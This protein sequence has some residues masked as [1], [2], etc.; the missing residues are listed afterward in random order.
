V[1]IDG[2]TPTDERQEVQARLARGD[3]T[4]LVLDFLPQMNRDL[5]EHAKPRD[6]IDQSEQWPVQL[7]RGLD[8]LDC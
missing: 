7:V 2:D 5:Y 6:R 3:N 1:Y 4:V 8:E